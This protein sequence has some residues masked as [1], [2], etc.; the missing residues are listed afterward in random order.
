MSLF[1]NQVP[2]G[3]IKM[4][5]YDLQGRWM[6]ICSHSYDLM[7]GIGH[8]AVLNAPS[9]EVLIPSDL[10]SSAD[11]ELQT[12]HDVMLKSMRVTA[13]RLTSGTIESTAQ[14]SPPYHEQCP[15]AMRGSGR[16]SASSSTRRADCV[17]HHYEAH[18]ATPAELPQI[19]VSPSQ[20]M[21]GYPRGRDEDLNA[22]VTHLARRCCA[23]D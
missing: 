21:D 23:E 7:N 22:T 19:V 14:Q 20:M 1:F 6:G 4:P 8:R 9:Y 2:I 3:P 13:R 18:R 16:A 15:T 5:G 17:Q 12:I 10:N 11:P